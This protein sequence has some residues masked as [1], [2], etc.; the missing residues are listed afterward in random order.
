M[1]M[2]GALLISCTIVTMAASAEPEFVGML[3]IAV[4][5]DVAKRIG[6]DEPQRQRLQELIENRENAV[7]KLRTELKNLSN[8]DEQIRLAEFRHESE[9]KGKELL[10]PDQWESL[11]RVWLKRRGMESLADKKIADLLNLSEEQRRKLMDLLQQ[12]RERMA[13]A[14]LDSQHT[15]IN[16][17]GRQ[18][19]E[20]LTDEQ[21]A[22]WDLITS[23]DA[24]MAPPAAA[25]PSDGPPPAPPG[26]PPAPSGPPPAEQTPVE[27]ADA[28]PPAE[29]PEDAMPPKP[30]E[31]E[32]V[33]TVVPQEPVKP[34][35]G[36]PEPIQPP[37]EDAMVPPSKES[38]RPNDPTWIDPIV[39]GDS[40]EALDVRP[41]LPLP[42]ESDKLTFNF[43]YQP[44]EDVINW[45]A[46]RAGLSLLKETLPAGTFNYRDNREYTPIEALNL[47]NKALLIKGYR[48]IKAERMLIVIDLEDGIP[49]DLITTVSLEE[50]DELSEYDLVR[51]LFELEKFDPA[52]AEQEIQ[53]L[54]GPQGSMIVMPKSRQI[55]VTDT[56]GNLKTIHRVIQRIEDPEGIAS[57]DVGVYQPQYILADEAMMVLRQ[58]LDIDEEENATSDGSLRVAIDALGTKLYFSGKSEMR[59]K[60]SQILETIDQAPMGADEGV[61]ESLQ[62]EIYP[63]T[64]ADPNSVLSVMQ[65]LL[66]ESPGVRLSLDPKTN[67][68]I[69]LARPSQHATI[70]ATLD[71]MQSEVRR[72][73]VI[74]LR[75]V[76]PALAALSIKKMFGEASKENTSSPTVE[77]D[78]AARQLLVYGTDSQ[79]EQIGVLLEKMGE[80]NIGGAK[81]VDTST[82]R[83]LPLGGREAEAVLE[84][85]EMIWPT[86]RENRIK[87]VTPSAVIPTL[88]PGSKSEPAP[89]GEDVLQEL[90]RMSPDFRVPALQGAAPAKPA[91]GPPA[92]KPPT[93]APPAAAPPAAAPVESALPDPPPRTQKSAATDRPVSSAWAPIRLVSE[94]NDQPK[95]VAKSTESAEPASQPAKPNPTG[96]TTDPPS[97]PAAL[98]QE[99]A[100]GDP[101]PVVVSIGSGGLM[102]ACEDIDAL[103]EFEDLVNM[104]SAGAVSSS[105]RMTVFYLIHAKAEPVA[106]TI[107][108]ILGGGTMAASSGGSGGGGLLGDLAGAALGDMGGGIVS[109]LLGFGMGGGSITPTGSIQITPDSRLNCLFVQANSADLNMIEQ[110]LKI[111]D[112]SGSPEDVLADPK[113]QMIPVH[114]TQAQEISEIVQQ[115]FQENLA[116]TARNRQ[117]SPQ[118]FM[119]A[120]RGGGRGGSRG[121]SRGKS[122][123]TTP[124]MSIGVDARSNSLIV[125]AP[126]ALFQEVKLLVEALDQAAAESN[127]DSIQVVRLDRLNPAAMRAALQAVVGDNVTFGS[128]SS[129]R[130]R[131]SSG[132][133]S[134]SSG[135]PPESSSS[136]DIRRQMFMRAMQERMGGGGSPFGGGRPG[137]GGPSGG[138][139]FGGGRPGGGGPSSGGRSGG[140][141]PGGGGRPGGR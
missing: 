137:G 58:L 67:S 2:I 18:L 138:S 136:D 118:E 82:V 127:N 123:D 42:S 107:D 33:E 73:E 74:Y 35:P 125:S 85:I 56:V 26:L 29:R 65:T 77:A 17:T 24:P 45:F 55:L 108:A 72:I 78:S 53:K 76:D 14:D 8:E 117:P 12:R 50:L 47:L 49:P 32:P 139:P 101:P 109:S 113:P 48:L 121:S 10:K 4:E 36:E 96:Q 97:P 115:V 114:N 140:G 88:R 81:F 54:V 69:A 61:I 9:A 106:E 104:L 59:A 79:I 93:K 111:L 112:Q 43:S 31:P 27:S 133:P 132:R 130:G 28:E 87:V 57:G 3:A 116:S 68:L 110:L 124:K 22:K 25:S 94:D 40:A 52:E 6:L 119:E 126:E 90:L 37:A 46:D 134:S 122:T 5:E 99:K 91:T 89:L 34:E 70:R 15:I 83:M 75:S 1:S 95:P 84:R 102:I 23:L 41:E 38:V 30:V 39:P 13:N 92:A 51:V 86:M 11:R 20:L 60:V 16:E 105:P 7:T 66:A 141:G 44:W 21:R 131:S 135:R 64:T 100:A 129:S 128:S 120:L 71:Q 63:V 103:N 62:M 19:A 98:L 80:K